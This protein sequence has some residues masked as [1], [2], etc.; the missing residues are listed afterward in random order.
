MK[1]C[2]SQ[3]YYKTEKQLSSSGCYMLYTTTATKGCCLTGPCGKL[4]TSGRSIIIIMNNDDK[5]HQI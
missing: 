2:V 5:L 3:Y 4:T 1:L